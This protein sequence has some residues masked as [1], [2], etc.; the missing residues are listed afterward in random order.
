VTQLADRIRTSLRDVADFPQPG[1][2]FKDI[3]PLMR[4][5]EMVAAVISD[6]ASH[7]QDLGVTT[8]VGIEAR[9][10]LLAGPLAH[11]LGLGVVPVRKAGKLPGQVLRADY[12]LEY[13]TAVLEIATDAFDRPAAGDKVLL[14]DDV[15]ATGGTASA[16]ANLVRRAGGQPVGLA[17]L[18]ELTALGGRKRL[19]TDLPVYAQLT[20]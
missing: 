15:L 17:V 5:P 12:A 16:A 8:V 1:V 19:G 11:S 20:D 10:F 6:L 2:T 14:V 3:G 18:I 7:A 4:D 13:G 9:G